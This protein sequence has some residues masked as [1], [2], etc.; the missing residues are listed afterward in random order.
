MA[1]DDPPTMYSARPTVR[2]SDTE[3]PLLSAQISAMK[4]REAL[5]GL[6]SLEISFSDW[7]SASDGSS[8]FGATGDDQPLKLGEPIILYA[9]ETMSPQEIFSGVITA[10]EGELDPIKAP[11]I[12][13]LAEDLL[14]AARREKRSRLFDDM[15]PKQVIEQ[16][17]GDYG[18]SP[19]VRDGLD[20]PVKKW[21]QMGETDLTFMRRV[22]ATVDADLQL[23]GAE[24]QVGPIARDER[25]SVELTF[26]Q[27]LV[28]IRTIADL[29]HQFAQTSISAM[30]IAG[31]AMVLGTADEGEMGPGEGPVAKDILDEKFSP[32]RNHIRHHEPLDQEWADSQARSA[33]GKNAR[34]FVTAEGTAVGNAEIRVGSWLTLFGTNPMFTNQ[35]NVVEAIHRFDR[36]NGYMT[37]FTAQCAHFGGAV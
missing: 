34:A 18:L 5:G 29:A 26:P 24:L 16:I 31:G 3:Y 19:Q 36:E 21:A 12:T 9:G 25:T 2:I 11:T 23:V 8:G 10:V 4:M 13:I 1:R 37:D 14:F 33:F 6:S 32:Y 15:S 30:D 7:I 27:S 28:R 20:Q 22:L 35:Y 17:A